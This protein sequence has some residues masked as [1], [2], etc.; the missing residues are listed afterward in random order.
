MSKSRTTTP[1]LQGFF[2]DN[3]GIVGDEREIETSDSL[4]AQ[5][6]ELD[7]QARVLRLKASALRTK[8]AIKRSEEHLKRT[9]EQAKREE[10]RVRR[11]LNPSAKISF[12]SFNSFGGTPIPPLSVEGVEPQ[13]LFTQITNDDRI[14]N[15]DSQPGVGYVE[16]IVQKSDGDKKK[17][18]ATILSQ[19]QIFEGHSMRVENRFNN[20]SGFTMWIRVIDPSG[21]LSKVYRF[22]TT[23]N[24][25]DTVRGQID[26]YF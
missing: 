20:G 22:S 25:I 8:E 15:I 2:E 26:Q 23:Q 10:E 11:G 4:E 7:S 6:R 14:L 17:Y 19:K 1:N 21:L 5:A 16:V 13:D 3:G 18:L 24:T 9:E 12:G